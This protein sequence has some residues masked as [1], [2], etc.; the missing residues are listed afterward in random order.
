MLLF[1]QDAK[2]RLNPIYGC[3]IDLNHANELCNRLHFFKKKAV[4]KKKVVVEKKAVTSGKDVTAC[5]LF[6]DSNFF[7][8]VDIDARFGWFLYL[9]SI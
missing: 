6:V 3:R 2:L 7:V 5:M 1:I 4:C 8:V 9:L